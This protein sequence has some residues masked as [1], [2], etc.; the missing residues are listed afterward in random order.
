MN[1]LND[2]IICLMDTFSIPAIIMNSSPYPTQWNTV[3]LN[4]TAVEK[5]KYSQSLINGCLK[6][7]ILPKTLELKPNRNGRLLD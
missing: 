3:G 4:N 1:D 2:L 7:N 5:D 6:M